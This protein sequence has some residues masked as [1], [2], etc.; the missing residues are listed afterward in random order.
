[1]TAKIFPK[2]TIRGHHESNFSNTKREE[3][4]AKFT[5]NTKFLVNSQ[6]INF[7][8][9]QKDQLSSDSVAYS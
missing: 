7:D 2:K 9:Y 1:M 5:G 6:L 3:N 4:I 8:F